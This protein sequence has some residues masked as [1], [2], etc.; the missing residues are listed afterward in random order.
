MTVRLNEQ[1][2]ELLFR[3]DP[4]RDELDRVATLVELAAQQNAA[5]IM[6]RFPG[7]MDEIVVHSVEMD[8]SGLVAKVGVADPNQKIGR[9]LDEKEQREHSWLA[10]ALQQ[11]NGA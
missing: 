6:H 2:L 11:V 5:K 9:Y 3:S 4:V 10:P 1:A 8:T 7:A